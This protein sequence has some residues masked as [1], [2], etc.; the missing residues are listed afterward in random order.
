MSATVPCRRC[1]TQNPNGARRCTQCNVW[2]PHPPAWGL[3][4]VL[5]AVLVVALV[6]ALV[7]R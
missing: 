1:H 5:A 4:V 3:A 6:A 7:R 2:M